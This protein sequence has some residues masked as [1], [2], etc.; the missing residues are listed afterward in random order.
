[1]F[2]LTETDSSDRPEES[3]N[4]TIGP[5]KL[6]EDVCSAARRCHIVTQRGQPGTVIGA[7]IGALEHRE[8]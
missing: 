3:R 8:G 2:G 6:T 4:D 1:L 5:P 7:E